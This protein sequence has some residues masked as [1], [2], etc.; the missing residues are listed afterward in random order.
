MRLLIIEDS[1]RLRTTAARALTRL[2]HAVDEAESAEEGDQLA[3]DNEYDAIVLDRMLPGEDGLSLL[4]RW[5]SAGRDTPVLLLTALHAV[6]ERVRGLAVGAD[7]YLT[8]PF[9]LAE[10]AARL[11]ALARRSHG[12][13]DSK[14]RI[15]PLEID[16]AAKGVT[17]DGKPVALTAREF[18]LLECLA[19][20]PGQVMNRE[21][22]EAHLYNEADSPLSNA[23]DAAVYSLRR[24]LCPR[25]TPPLL[26]TRRGL[27]YVLQ[28]EA[29]ET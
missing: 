21:Q 19:R 12:K 28:Q 11:E 9:A 1:E 22:I 24:K 5:R 10:L 20:R 27:G 23:V 15:G 17:R 3:R 29:E 25:G 14:V 13:A 18:S 26:H 8:K 4:S 7:D 6:E 2:G 16:F